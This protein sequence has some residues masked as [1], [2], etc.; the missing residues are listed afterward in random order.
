MKSDPW[1]GL[2][3]LDSNPQTRGVLADKTH[4]LEFYW[5]K[6]FD[7]NLLFVLQASSKI[8]MKSKVPNLNGITVK[9]G[10]HQN[11]N[12]LILALSS[13]KD[14]D[15]FYTLCRDLLE[16]TRGMKDTDSAVSALFRRLLTWQHFL[17]S[18]RKPVDKRQLQGLIGELLFLQRY[19]LEKYEVEDALAFWKAPLE[20]VHDFELS[21]FTVEVK[22]K[23]SVNSITISSYEQL[24][25]ELDHLLLYVATLNQ[26]ADKTPGSFNIFDLLEDIRNTIRN[27]NSL[28]LNKFDSLLHS[29]G[30]IELEE[31]RENFYIFQGEKFYEVKE[32]FPRIGQVPDGIDKLTYRINLDKC[33]DFIADSDLLEKV[34]M[35]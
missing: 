10:R 35:E 22:T 33:K 16:H 13:K 15:I 21:N 25:S 28:V 20:S 18:N 31:Y 5:A 14:R 26:S 2:E 32:N 30:F 17:Q 8:I 27:K 1:K 29:Y 19:L 6:D 3:P 23:S 7:D 12:Q 24:Y 4:I 11:N 9:V 34:G